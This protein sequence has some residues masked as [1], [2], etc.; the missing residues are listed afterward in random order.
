MGVLEGKEVS[1]GRRV[2]TAAE[3]TYVAAALTSVLQL[4]RLVAIA[5]RDND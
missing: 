1:Q 3:L 5:N 2:L 4:L